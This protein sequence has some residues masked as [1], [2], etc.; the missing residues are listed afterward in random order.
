MTCVGEIC[1][2]PVPA[3]P[4]KD[5][6]DTTSGIFDITGTDEFV[7]VLFPNWP[8]ELSPQAQ[9]VPSD[10]SVRES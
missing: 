6:P 4:P 3:T 8:E 5:T 2:N 10:T 9:A 7:V 1:V